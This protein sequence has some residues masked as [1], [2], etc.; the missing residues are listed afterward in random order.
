MKFDITKQP[1][2]D[3]VQEKLSQKFP[4]YDLKMRGKQFLIVKKSATC[5]VNILIRKNKIMVNGNFP[6]MGAQLLFTFTLVMLGILIPLIIYFLT[7]H[8]KFK[9]MENEVGEF[10]KSEFG[11]F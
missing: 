3:E 5:G 2:F 9:A 11:G 8:K 1:T 10:L 4:Q 6:S 7:F